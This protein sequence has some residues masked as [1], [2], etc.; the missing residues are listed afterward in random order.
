MDGLTDGWM[1]GWMDGVVVTVMVRRRMR[2]RGEEGR[3]GIWRDREFG[4]GGMTTTRPIN[5]TSLLSL[6]CG[7]LQITNKAPPIPF[8]RRNGRHKF[9]L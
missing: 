9:T 8:Y 3:I 6:Q 5:L 7:A 1:N 2:E 4:E